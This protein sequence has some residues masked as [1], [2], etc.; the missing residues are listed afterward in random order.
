M[1]KV[2][3]LRMNGKEVFVT[4]LI[5]GFLV[6]FAFLAAD[7]FDRLGFNTNCVSSENI[8]YFVSR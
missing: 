1:N 8:S 5:Y 3:D 2:I 7:R 6:L 4:L